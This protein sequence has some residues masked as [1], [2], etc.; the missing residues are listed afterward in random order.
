M[1]KVI[2]ILMPGLLFFGCEK[3]ADIS[4]RM[5]NHSAGTIK[6]VFFNTNG[7]D[8]N[9]FNKRDSVLIPPH[10]TTILTTQGKGNSRVSRY[11]ESDEYLKEFEYIAVYHDDIVAK[12]N[13]LKSEKWEYQEK[14][15]HLANY[16]CS[17]FQSDF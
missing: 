17:V 9:T 1:K 15:K 10:S 8:R 2:T 5:T 11:K 13:F 3:V 16:V 7:S 14:N 4:Y 6:V 12:T